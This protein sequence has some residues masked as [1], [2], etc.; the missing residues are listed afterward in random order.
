MRYFYTLL[1]CLFLGNAAPA[2]HTVLW[3]ITRPNHPQVSWM[4]GTLHVLGESFIDSFPLIKDRLM[5]SDLLVTEAPT[6]RQAILDA[7]SAR[8]ASDTLKSMVSPQQLDQIKEI[9]HRSSVDI[10]KLTPSELILQLTVFYFE[11]GCHPASVNDKYTCDEYIQQLA[12]DNHKPAYFFETDSMQEKLLEDKSQNWKY[13]KK[14]VGPILSLYKMKPMASVCKI[15]WN[16]LA[17]TI[18]YDFDKNCTDKNIVENRNAAWMQQLPA[19]LDQHNCFI[20]VGLQ[21]LCNSCGLIVR[22]RALGYTV[23]PVEMR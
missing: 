8:P 7:I 11:A 3:K 15:V 13:F 6:N 4:I 19:E 20:D 5:A 16:Y 21:H 17:F 9:Y 14:R 1:L 18:D 22:L 10:F 12:R 2:Q 23:E